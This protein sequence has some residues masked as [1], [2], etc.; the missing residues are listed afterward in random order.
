ME[1]DKKTKRR[2]KRDGKAEGKPK[3]KPKAKAGVKKHALKPKAKAGPPKPMSP[4]KDGGAASGSSCDRRGVAAVN[5]LKELHE[6][7][8]L[9][10]ELPP[11]NSFTKK[12]LSLIFFEIQKKCG[13]IHHDILF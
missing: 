11:L 1:A 13:K 7:S 3:A 9:G 10:F 4:P 6:I 5:A 2:D 12:C 8:G